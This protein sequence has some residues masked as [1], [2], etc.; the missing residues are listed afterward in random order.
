MINCKCINYARK[1]D[2]LKDFH[3]TH[4]KA[5]E[6]YD[7]DEV[8]IYTYKNGENRT[9]ITHIIPLDMVSNEDVHVS[10]IAMSKKEYLKI[11]EEN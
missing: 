1:F 5:C 8:I 6:H 10:T 11:V 7:E 3:N 9:V 2:F 4:H